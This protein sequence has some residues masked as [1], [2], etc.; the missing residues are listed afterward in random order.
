V[1][2]KLF[3]AVLAAGVALSSLAHA[4]DALTFGGLTLCSIV[5]NER[6]EPLAA[7]RSGWMLGYWSALNASHQQSWVGEK[8]AGATND[9]DPIIMAVWNECLRSGHQSL[10][11]A[12][13]TVYFQT[14][15]A[16][17]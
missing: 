11:N 8:M 3:A 7:F 6:N 9:G 16:G 4:E 15:Q 1:K 10:Q 17:Q 13:E 14:M 2:T 12:V 5:V